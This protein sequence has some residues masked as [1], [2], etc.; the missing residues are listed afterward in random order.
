M[1]ASSHILCSERWLCTY[2][3]INA[4]QLWTQMCGKKQVYLWHESYGEGNLTL[5]SVL[6]P[7]VVERSW[8]QLNIIDTLHLYCKS[9][10]KPAAGI[11]LIFCDFLWLTAVASQ[12]TDQI[13]MLL[14]PTD[15]T[16]RTKDYL[17]I[18][19]NAWRNSSTFGEIGLFCQRVIQEDWYQSQFCTLNTELDS[20]WH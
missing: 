9:V 17:M 12:Q 3:K 19:T 18:W 2:S 13:S 6:L 20:S 1:T 10:S 16:E 11:H 14:Q 15:T 8:K 4:T 5:K 7:T